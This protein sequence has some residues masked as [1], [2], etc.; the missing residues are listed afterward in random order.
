[1]TI[2]QRAKLP[3]LFMITWRRLAP[4]SGFVLFML[5]AA[6]WRSG[7]T[8]ALDFAASAGLSRIA[9][10]VT[11][12]GNQ[13][14]VSADRTLCVC[15]YPDR[16]LQ[17]LLGCYEVATNGGSYSIPAT[18]TYYLIAFLDP[19]LNVALDPGE[20]FQ[21]YRNKGAPPADPVVAGPTQSA[22]DF[23]F[24]DENLAGTPTPS[25][26]TPLTETSTPTP[27]DTS[28]P[29]STETPEP[30]PTETPALT[31]TLTDTPAPTETA[32]PTASPEPTDTPRSTVTPTSVAPP[33][34]GDCDGNSL[35]TI[36]ELLN[37]VDT[38]LG[39]APLSC[40]AGDIDGNGVIAVNEILTAVNRALNGCA[41]P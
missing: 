35:V 20:P 4:T 41:A 10:T 26:T 27:T 11:Y 38:A 36:A 17:I 14:P 40:T 25:P 29:P 33:C 37:L 22:V 32:A 19:N 1:M 7:Q 5:A 3:V 8:A 12:S 16:T 18:G 21:I 2:D 6:A 23:N 30:P 13:G 39:T 34:A 24:G 15:L 31:A 9:G 28:T